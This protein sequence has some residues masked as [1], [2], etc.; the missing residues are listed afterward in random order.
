LSY[1][2]AVSGVVIAKANSSV[3]LVVC[4]VCRCAVLVSVVV[5]IKRA[6]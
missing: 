1:Y 2:H 3:V 4:T 6:C 5:V